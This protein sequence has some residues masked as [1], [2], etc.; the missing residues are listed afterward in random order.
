MAAE[1]D[2]VIFEERPK[3]SKDS[4]TAEEP[5]DTKGDQMEAFNEET[6][7]IN[8]DCP[9]IA[10]LVKPPCGEQFKEAFSCFVYSKEEVRGSDCVEQFKEMQLCFQKHPEVYGQDEEED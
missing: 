4:S 3:D 9:C 10:D 2:I 1:K 6:N 7:E 5:K 8:W